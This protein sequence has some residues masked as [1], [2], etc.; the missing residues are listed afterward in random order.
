MEEEKNPAKRGPGLQ[1]SDTELQKS[2]ARE[3]SQ[4][5]SGLLNTQDMDRFLQSF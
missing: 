4:V 3:A 1:N 2:I 5:S